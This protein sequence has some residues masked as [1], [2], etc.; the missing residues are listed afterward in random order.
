MTSS[1]YDPSENTVRVAGFT[2]TGVTSIE[3]RRAVDDFKVVH[4]I[5]PIYSARVRNYKRP[6]TLTVKLLQ[7]SESNSVLQ[8]LSASSEAMFNSF[9]RVEVESKRPGIL[10]LTQGEKIV[11]LSSTGYVLSAPDLSLDSNTSDRTWVF[12]VNAFDVGSITD[13]FS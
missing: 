13:L 4:G 7:T 8:Y 6:F 9:F 11:H 12:A 10:S 1:V 5:N 2:L 3:V